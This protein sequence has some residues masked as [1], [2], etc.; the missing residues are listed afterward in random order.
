MKDR[1]KVYP[2]PY[3]RFGPP[4]S[5]TTSE[6]LEYKRATPFLLQAESTRARPM[7]RITPRLRCR[8]SLWPRVAARKVLL[9]SQIKDASATQAPHAAIIS[10]TY[11]VLSGSVS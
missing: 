6:W 8:N 1:D 3:T 11:A 5:I 10:T 9:T 7:Y 2:R 4:L